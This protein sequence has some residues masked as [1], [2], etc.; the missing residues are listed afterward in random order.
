M[1]AERVHLLS[2]PVVAIRRRLL[3]ARPTR[4]E[5]V[6]RAGLCAYPFWLTFTGVSPRR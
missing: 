6:L 3:K 4:F 2:R 5:A 1:C